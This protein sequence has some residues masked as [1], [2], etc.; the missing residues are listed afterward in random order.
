MKLTILISFVTLVQIFLVSLQLNWHYHRYL[1]SMILF[2]WQKAMTFF[3][4]HWNQTLSPLQL[5]QP[6]ET[7]QAVV[8]N[9]EIVDLEGLQDI[10][11]LVATIATPLAINHNR[12]AYNPRCQICK[13]DGHTAALCKNS[14]DRTDS[15]AHLA[16]A[17]QSS[18]SSTTGSSAS[19]WY[20]DT[21]APAHMTPD[22]TSLD[23]SE[24]Y[25]GNW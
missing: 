16:E 18:C 24:Q 21:G 3:R 5:S 12:R 11:L 8:V 1:A 22:V 10:I 6:H 20:L 19:D 13:S 17:F 9:L 14:Y 2:R 25:D 23:S 4:S 15:S 7:S